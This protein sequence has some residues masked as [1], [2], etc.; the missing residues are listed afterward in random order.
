MKNNF[1]LMF[2]KALD[3]NYYI[4]ESKIGCSILKN[5][6][7]LD[8]TLAMLLKVK[9]IRAVI[10]SIFLNPTTFVWTFFYKTYIWDIHVLTFLGHSV[11]VM[12]SGNNDSYMS[13]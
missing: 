4:L 11:Y 5:R 13:E 7:D 12:R 3:T 8:L 2:W 10:K 6:C 1:I 9:L